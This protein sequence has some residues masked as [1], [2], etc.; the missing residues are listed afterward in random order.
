MKKTS[1]LLII[2]VI[3]SAVMTIMF[4]GCNREKTGDVNSSSVSSSVTASSSASE[5]SSDS[6]LVSVSSI[7]SSSTPGS[8]ISSSSTSNISSISSKSSSTSSSKT[9]SSSSSSSSSKSTSSSSTST[10]VKQA[11]TL[12]LATTTSVND[13][14]LLDYLKPFLKSEENISLDVLAQGSGQAIKTATDGN[15]DVLIAH[16]PAAEQAFVDSG[17]GVLKQQ[18]MYNFFAIAGPVA[19]PAKV[20]TAT[21]A[22]AAFSKIYNAYLKNPNCIFYSRDDKSGTDTKEKSIWVGNGFDVATFSP[23]FYKKTGKGMLDTLIMADNTDGYTLTDKATF[24]ANTDKLI[25]LKLLYEKSD[26]LKNVYS[27]TLISKDKYPDL[28]YDDAKRFHDWLLKPSTQQK[29][30]DYGKAK[31]GEALFFVN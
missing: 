11:V 14:G 19:D 10:V 26:E 31:Y 3:I 4:T 28:K 20:S 9:S 2:A 13:S 23:D 8:S 1:R 12:K 16:S 30:A 7:D 24:L 17:Y 29:I 25:N 6:S 21:S 18:F 27:V 15:C 22:S 5:Y